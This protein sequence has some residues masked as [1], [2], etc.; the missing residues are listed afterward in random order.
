M[1]DENDKIHSLWKEVE[2]C[3][4]GAQYQY[5]GRKTC[6]KLTNFAIMVLK[7]IVLPVY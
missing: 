1:K 3:F 6:K 5:K 2:F 7:L 4:K